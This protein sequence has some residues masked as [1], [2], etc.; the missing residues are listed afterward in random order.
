MDTSNALRRAG[1]NWAASCLSP[2]GEECGGSCRYA[3]GPH[4][5]QCVPYVA[6]TRKCPPGAKQCADL[7]Q[8]LPG[9]L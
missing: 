3:R 4:T 7:V 9:P 2:E 6:G 5:G 1:N 8:C